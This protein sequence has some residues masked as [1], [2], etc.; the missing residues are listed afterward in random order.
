MDFILKYRPGHVNEVPRK[1]EITKVPV[2]PSGVEHFD[3]SIVIET[4]TKNKIETNKEFKKRASFRFK[5][6]QKAGL[7]SN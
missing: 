5:A 1:V 4:I 7:Y 6:I 3:R 2:S